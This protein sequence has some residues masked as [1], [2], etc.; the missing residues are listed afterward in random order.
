MPVGNRSLML[1][2]FRMR[3]FRAA[4][5]WEA[6]SFPPGILQNCYKRV[7]TE[8]QKI[9]RA[10]SYVCRSYKGKIPPHILNRVNK[11]NLNLSLSNYFYNTDLL[12]EKRAS[13]KR[14]RLYKQELKFHQKLW[15]T[16]GLQVTLFSR[17]L[18][19]KTIFI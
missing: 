3:P 9:L 7:K 8:I 2:L 1:T 15:I 12:L 19:V 4:Y 6:E 14:K 17:Y 18:V 16:Q 5:R 11:E 13:L 10:T